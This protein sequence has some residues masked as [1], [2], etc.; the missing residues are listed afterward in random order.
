MTNVSASRPQVVA[1]PTVDK[2]RIRAKIRTAPYNK[3]LALDFIEVLDKQIRKATRRSG[4]S[5][6]IE[7]HGRCVTVDVEDLH[8]MKKNIEKLFDEH[9]NY[10]PRHKK[11]RVMVKNSQILYD[12]LF[13]REELLPVMSV[14][15]QWN[16]FVQEAGIPILPGRANRD[17]PPL[18]KIGRQMQSEIALALKTVIKSDFGL[19]SYNK[20]LRPDM[21]PADLDRKLSKFIKELSAYCPLEKLLEIIDKYYDKPEQTRPKC[22]ISLGDIHISSFDDIRSKEG[23]RELVKA[24]I[25]MTM[26]ASEVEDLEEEIKAEKRSL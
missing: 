19:V 3:Y 26:D 6:K 13:I 11:N 10:H 16:A 25:A 18:D 1:G 15:E 12:F 14:R 17:M 9:G 2:E 20:G 4:S 24:L 5:L 21:D 22:S 8:D 23:R 7:T